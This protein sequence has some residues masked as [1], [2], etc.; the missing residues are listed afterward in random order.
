M[1]V[2]AIIIDKCI[3][4][5]VCGGKGGYNRASENH[6]SKPVHVDGDRPKVFCVVVR[7]KKL[8]GWPETTIYSSQ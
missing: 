1:I 4:V 3:C 6:L 8:V 5:C 7:R 2:I